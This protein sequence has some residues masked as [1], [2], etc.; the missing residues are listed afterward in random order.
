MGCRKKDPG[1]SVGSRRAFLFFFLFLTLLLPFLSC[2]FQG[3]SG[4][5]EE[6]KELRTG[7]WWI[8]DALGNWYIRFEAPRTAPERVC[9]HHRTPQGEERRLVAGSRLRTSV[10]APVLVEP[11]DEAGIYRLYEVPLTT[12]QGEYE[13][14]GIRMRAPEG[15][16]YPVRIAIM[17]DTNTNN[18][19]G[20]ERIFAR[21][22][23]E[24]WERTPHLWVHTGDIVYH[25]SLP[26]ASWAGFWAQAAPLLRRS[27]FLPAV[28]NHEYE[29]PEEY[30]SYTAPW[31]G[32]GEEEGLQ[33]VH[34]AD[35]GPVRL[36][37]LDSNSDEMSEAAWK[38]M[39][40]AA[41]KAL[42]VEKPWKG[43]MF[44]HPTYTTSTH[45]PRLDLRERLLSLD[46]EVDLN[47]VLHGHNH[48]FEWWSTEGFEVLVSGG[49]GAA[50]YRLG[51]HLTENEGA[52]NQMGI[53]AYHW[54]ELVISG[55]EASFVV[56]GTEGVLAEGRFRR[57]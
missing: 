35:V 41:R 46:A 32:V 1:E 22:I 34:V 54:V 55:E 45:A 56:H 33:R 36:V 6:L 29:F 42:A 40:E 28:G 15:S 12:P 49:G 16:T 18:E 19:E 9:V 2:R 14:A 4:E 53:A 21:W 31:L 44:H 38:G 43:I 51:E 10:Q 48:V 52:V 8:S 23:T 37:A 20:G 50:L 27:L 17:G 7:P 24:A 3:T 47:L 25:L 13:V 30:E 39:W 26:P 11:P 57:H 5:C